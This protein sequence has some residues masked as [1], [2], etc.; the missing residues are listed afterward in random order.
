M[1]DAP[2]SDAPVSDAPVSDAPVSDAPV[3]D[4]PTSE[5]SELTA[6]TD[7]PTPDGR[8]E[9][10]TSDRGPIGGDFSERRSALAR[11]VTDKDADGPKIFEGTNEISDDISVAP[12]SIDGGNTELDNEL[13]KAAIG[14]DNDGANAN[15]NAN[16][17]GDGD[18]DGDGAIGLA[19]ETNNGA[20]EGNDMD[21]DDLAATPL[22]SSSKNNSDGDLEGGEGGEGGEG[23]K[24]EVFD[25]NEPWVPGSPPLTNALSDLND[26]DEDDAGEE[27]TG[28][29]QP[30]EP[31]A[32]SNSQEDA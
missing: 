1:S 7:G 22:P 24:K 19:I 30:G 10:D 32:I 20:S 27:A 9:G 15:A 13:L 31:D 3:S 4:A 12:T 18:G 25:M 5:M 28:V 21:V 11:T 14:E 2:V 16:T 23:K 29:A 17:N 6:S 8:V 26:G